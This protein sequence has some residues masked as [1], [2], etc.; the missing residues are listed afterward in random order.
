M[1]MLYVSLKFF[2]DNRMKMIAK[3]STG[4]SVSLSFIHKITIIK[5]IRNYGDGEEQN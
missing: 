1:T 3:Y 4:R 5:E 2:S